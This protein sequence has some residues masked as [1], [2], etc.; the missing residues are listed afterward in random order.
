MCE[1]LSPDCFQNDFSFTFCFIHRIPFTLSTQIQASDNTLGNSCLRRY[2]LGPFKVRLLLRVHPLPASTRLVLF[3][4]LRGR[5]VFQKQGEGPCDEPCPRV[6]APEGR[7]WPSARSAGEDGGREGQP[8]G[9]GLCC[10]RPWCLE[11]SDHRTLLEVCK[12]VFLPF[13]AR[14]REK[15]NEEHNK[16]LSDTVDKLLSESNERLQLHLKERMAALEDKVRPHTASRGPAGG[17]SA[18]PG[19]SAQV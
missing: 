11:N 2:Q 14:Q 1:S 19:P 7:S 6:S 3:L 16:R 8:G 4:A 5:P 17:A 10:P 12:V 15:M 13:Q 18:R 9:G